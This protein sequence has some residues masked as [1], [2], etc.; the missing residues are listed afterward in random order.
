MLMDDLLG[1]ARA[2]IGWQLDAYNSL[3]VKAVG[4]LAFDS[5]LVTVAQAFTHGRQPY[6]TLFFIFIG[7][8]AVASLLSLWLRRIDVGPQAVEL[9][10]ATSG[11]PDLDA[12]EQLLADVAAATRANHR[13]LAQKGLYWT[14]GVA[15]LLLAMAAGSLSI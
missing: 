9:Y 3:E 1:L 7:L 4:L 14:L 8:S 13:P 12:Q 15:A 5:A 11:L 6:L 2:Q 10:V